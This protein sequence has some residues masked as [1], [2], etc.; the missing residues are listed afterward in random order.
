MNKNNVI[1]PLLLA[2]IASNLLCAQSSLNQ[3]KLSQTGFYHGEPKIAVITANTP[4]SDFFILDAASKDTVLKGSLG[5]EKQSLLSSTKTRIADFS[6][7]QKRGTYIV[8][9]P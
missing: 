8:D 9:V 1:L 4:G 7:L 6:A 3:I 2:F 5:S